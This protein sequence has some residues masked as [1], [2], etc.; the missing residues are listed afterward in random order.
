[1]IFHELLDIFEH[2]EGINRQKTDLETLT[3]LQLILV[4][5]IFHQP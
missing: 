4:W 3:H 5:K 2:S 1:M